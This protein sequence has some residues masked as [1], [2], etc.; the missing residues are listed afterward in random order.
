[1]MNLYDEKKVSMK[2]KNM[3]KKLYD[4]KVSASAINERVLNKCKWKRKLMFTMIMESMVEEW[5]EGALL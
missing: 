3:T 5:N 1:M 2:P 4:K